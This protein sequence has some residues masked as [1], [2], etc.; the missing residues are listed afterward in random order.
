MF[1]LVSSTN[2]H[3]FSGGAQAPSAGETRLGSIRR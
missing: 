2:N 1:D 3:A